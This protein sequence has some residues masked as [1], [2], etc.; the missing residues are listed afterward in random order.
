MFDLP[1]IHPLSS[2]IV[3]DEPMASSLPFYWYE[4]DCPNSGRRL[5]LPRTAF[6]EAIARG[7]MRQLA[8][9]GRFSQEG[10][11]Y[12]V[13]LVATPTGERGVL[14]AFSGLLHGQHWIEG[15][16]PPIPGRDHVALEE[17]RT[18]AALNTIKE[19][20]LA[21]QHLPERQQYAATLQ[22][23]EQ[24]LADLAQRH[25]QRQQERQQQ[26]QVLSLRLSSDSLTEALQALDEQSRRDGL[27]RR[28]LKQ[29]RNA[30]LQP[31]KQR[32]EQADAR[33]R[34]LKQQRKA[35][36]QQLQFQ[37][38]SAYYL[39]N[40]A[41]ES[42]SIHQFLPKGSMP[43][44]TG[45]CCAPKL[46]H[47]AATQGLKPLALAEFWW[48]PPTPN[49]DKQQGEFYGACA[50]R[51][52]P[53]M[54]FLL[55]GLPER[56]PVSVADLASPPLT[57]VYEDDGLI[58]V[59]KPAGLLS[60]PGRYGDRQDSVLSRLR[61]QLSASLVAVHRLDQDTSGL[62]L[63]ARD[64][65]SYRL[66][67]QQFQQQQVQKIYEAV[68]AGQVDRDRGRIDLPLW[69]DPRDR[70]R[71]T[72][73]WQRGKPS[74]TE[75]QVVATTGDRS[76]LEFRPHTGRTH[77]LRVHAAAPEGLGVPILGDRL[78]GNG[79]QGDRLHL[80]ARELKFKHPQSGEWMH[81]LSD[82]PF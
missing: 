14:K 74:L 1:E 45:D 32:L 75:F 12:G 4:G 13:L 63:L 49:G 44:G 50:E 31:L 15:W 80:H 51:C 71:Q 52:Q 20:L 40:F 23:F 29:A 47:Y 54:G 76:R 16:V 41:G 21:L 70:P 77:Q 35:L 48:G 61:Y 82:T 3:G 18:L 30:H 55:S 25:Q 36:S 78:Y 68:L 38:Q 81:L 56:S 65:L 57:I 37:M 42:R 79:M 11:M 7:L 46:L 64:P 34:T 53:L 2:F 27:E 66:L 9:D 60:V 67:S 28:H 72:V 24:Q 59:N 5:R 8:Q 62:L 58:A 39:T 17:V 69:G 26:R 10:K 73:D 43:T 19:E 33:I 22:D 6:I